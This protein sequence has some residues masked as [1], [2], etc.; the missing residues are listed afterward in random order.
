M[1]DEEKVKVFY[2]IGLFLH[3]SVDK[4]MCFVDRKHAFR[5]IK[6]MLLSIKSI[7]LISRKI[8]KNCNALIINALQFCSFSRYFRKNNFSLKTA[9][10]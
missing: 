7:A 5:C 9:Q 1:N 3:F 6:A 10:G 2:E 8:N 4:S